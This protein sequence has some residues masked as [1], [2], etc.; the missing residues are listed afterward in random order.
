MK[1]SKQDRLIKSF[2]RYEELAQLNL[3]GAKVLAAH[4]L[5]GKPGDAKVP[6]LF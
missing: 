6:S 5:W 2:P 4:I 3:D 1:E